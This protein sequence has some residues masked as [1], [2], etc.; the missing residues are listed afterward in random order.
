MYSCKNP[1]IF[2]LVLTSLLLVGCTGKTKSRWQTSVS[3]F[4]SK[5]SPARY[6]SSHQN[7]AYTV[8][9]GDRLQVGVFGEPTLTGEY[10]VDGTGTISMPLLRSVRVAGLTTRQVS[11][12]ITTRLRKKFLRNPNVSV[13][14]TT[15]RP[16][17]ILG[18]VTNSGQYP[19]VDGMD[20]QTAVA[21]AGGFTPRARQSRFKITRK[22]AN[23]R[24]RTL[25]LRRTAILQ[26]G[27][28]IVVEERFF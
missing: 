9:Q 26:P 21:I 10:A 11:Q 19:Y 3:N 18:E 24:S 12:R 23:N 1:L 7:T 15:F 17:Y 22:D 20:V 5:S 4:S 8:G 28:T 2:I 27:D 25:T 16:F 13:E 14:V 6:S